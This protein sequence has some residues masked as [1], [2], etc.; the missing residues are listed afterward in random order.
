MK[1]MNWNKLN[2]CI[3]KDYDVYENISKNNSWKIFKHKIFKLR[4]IIEYHNSKSK[5]SYLW[6]KIITSGVSNQD[7]I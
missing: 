7:N 6:N 3:C 5:T 4:D 2:W 1:E